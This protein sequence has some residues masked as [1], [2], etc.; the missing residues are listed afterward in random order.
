MFLS[1]LETGREHTEWPN[2]TDL[3]E[4]VGTNQTNGNKSA[5]PSSTQ[6][7]KELLLEWILQTL[8]ISRPTSANPDSEKPIL[9]QS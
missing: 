5:I 4:S 3:L 1:I 2:M 9:G 6:L 7:I 8:K